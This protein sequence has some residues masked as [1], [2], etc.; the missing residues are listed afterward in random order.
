MKTKVLT[1]ILLAALYINIF[2]TAFSGLTAK[3]H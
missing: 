1:A 3:V 2:T